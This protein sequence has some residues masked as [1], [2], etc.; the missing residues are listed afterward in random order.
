MSPR[1]AEA[2]PL[3]AIFLFPLIWRPEEV[4]FARPFELLEG[5]CSGGVFLLSGRRLRDLKLGPFRLYSGLS[6]DSAVGRFVRRLWAQLWLPLQI[7]R[8]RGPVDIVVSYDPYGS[9]FNGI[10]LK[11]FF[12]AKLIVE[13]NGDHHEHRPSESRLKNWLMDRVFRA[14]LRAADAVKVL[15]SSQEA[16][17]R[18]SFPGKRV[19]RFSCFVADSYFRSLQTTQGDYLLSIGH[20]FAPKGVQ[21]L[22]RAFQRVSP[23]HPKAELRIMGYCEPA[24]LESYRELAKHDPRVQF[25]PPGWTSDVGEQLRGCYALAHAAHFEAFGRVLVEAMA[26]KKPIVAT[27]T[28]GAVDVVEDG[29]TGL[30]CEIRDPVDLAEKL[31]ALLSDPERAREMGEAGFE[32]LLREYDEERFTASYV[33]MLREVAAQPR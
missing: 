1:A 4:N 20:P 15:N 21:D 22:I 25:V 26:C 8:Q 2:R 29:R 9:A 11:R 16:F 17:I 10:L 18:R 13:I 30:L 14:S 24:E 3:Q 6:A 32:R 33:R 23:K 31:D 28:N 7:M 19:Y 27:R 12:G 5:A